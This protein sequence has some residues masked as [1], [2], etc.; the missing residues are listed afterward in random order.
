MKKKSKK[1]LKNKT[2]NNQLLYE[3]KTPLRDILYDE[4]P[5]FNENFFMYNL[6]F[7]ISSFGI[8]RQC[9]QEILQRCPPK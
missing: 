1:L 4:L 7:E 5:P 2:K 6:K 9:Q 8:R 3:I